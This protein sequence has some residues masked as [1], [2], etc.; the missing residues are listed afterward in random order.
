MNRTQAMHGLNA[1][2]LLRLLEAGHGRGPLDRGLLLLA[3]A[4]PNAGADALRALPVA[5]RDRRLV[6]LR[7]A[8]FG[9]SMEVMV[10]CPDCDTGL[11]TPMDLVLLSSL[12]GP[13]DPGGL[14]RHGDLSFRLPSTDDLAAVLATVDDD[15]RRAL[16]RRTLESPDP[17][18]LG[19]DDLDELVPVLAA[20]WEAVDPM[21]EVR[22]DFQCVGCELEFQRIFDIAEAFYAEVE[23]HGRRLLLDIHALASTYGWTENEVLALGPV[24]RRLYV[25]MV[26]ARGQGSA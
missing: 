1:T 10:R 15:P 18:A 7:R 25:D 22:L 8:T 3:Y 23:A 14:H 12:P 26:S 4:W 24:R 16:L 13:E 20:A 2:D 5:E 9:R 6:A 11:E 17:S 19:D 21:V